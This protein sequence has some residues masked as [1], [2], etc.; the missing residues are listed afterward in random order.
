MA[1]AGGRPRAAAGPARASVP[2]TLRAA[3]GVLAPIAAQGV[4]LRRPRMV[5]LAERLQAD[6][7]AGRL[8][9]RLRARYGPGPLRLRVPGR[10]VALVLAP[11]DVRRVLEGSPEPFAVANREKRAALSHF[12]P[13]GLLV[14]SGVVRTDRR[15]V[16]ETVLDYGR[17]LHRL[18]GGF[19]AT[20]AE[21]TG[22]LLTAAGS[23]G[24]LDWEDFSAAWWRIVRRVVLGDAARDDRELTDLLTALRADANWAFLRPRRTG[25]RRR[26]LARLQEHLDRAEPGSLAALLAATPATAGTRRAGQVPQWLFAFDAAGMAAWRGLALLATHPAQAARAGQELAGTG[27]PSAPWELPYLRA[28]LLESVRLWPTT[29]AVLRDTTSE[30][31]WAGGV[32]PAGTAVVVVSS[33]FSRDRQAV[34]AA[35]RFEPERWL[36][37]RATGNWSLIPFSAGPGTCAGRDLVLFLT[38]VLLAA[39]LDGHDLRLRQPA[40][41]DP[42]RPL[43]HTLNHATLGFAVASRA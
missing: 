28:C 13:D 22:P 4:I 21:E 15:R 23:P 16:N 24:A 26:F 29:L 38:S 33:C 39:L 42:D 11:D 10:S 35:D 1:E 25:L 2:D 41:L 5:S 12:Q 20:L 40:R 31:T 32:L 30:T 19:T 43:P 8:L 6:R 14:S 27:P 7:R 3:L 18:A 36:D 37:G 34:A 9:G 17:P